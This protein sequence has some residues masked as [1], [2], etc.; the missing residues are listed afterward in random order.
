L[1]YSF[2]IVLGNETFASIDLATFEIAPIDA[3]TT[4]GPFPTNFHESIIIGD[5]LYVYG[6]IDN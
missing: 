6:G 5:D 4:L 3:D 1:I 2:Q